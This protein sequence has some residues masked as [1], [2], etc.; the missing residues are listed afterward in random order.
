M[1]FLK[2]RLKAYAGFALRMLVGAVMTGVVSFVSAQELLENIPTGS[3][4]AGVS[5][6][7]SLTL[8]QVLE[9]AF[10][11]NPDMQAAEERI[12][13]AEAK[14]I[15]AT[16]NFYPKLIGQVG[17]TYTDNPAQAFSYI[18][19]QRRFQT[20]NLT[21]INN[22]GYVGNFRPELVG[23]ISLFEGGRD[24][25]RKKAAELGVEVS[26][27][28]RAALHNQLAAAVTA[29]YYAVL[30]APRE[31]EATRRSLAAVDS[32]LAH[33]REMHSA[34]SLL[35]SD[36]LSLEVRQAQAKE[37]ELQTLNAQESART[38][39][40]TLLGLG[41]GDVLDVREQ[42]LGRDKAPSKGLSVNLLSAALAQRPEMQIAA[43]QVEMREKELRA[44]IA[45]HMPRVDAY[46]AY[47]LNEQSPQFNFSKQN[48]TVGINAQIEIFGGGATSARVSAAERK[49]AEA[50]AL[51]ERVRLE[52]DAEVQRAQNNLSEV[53]ARQQVTETAQRSAEEALRLVHEQYRAGASSVT[54]YLEAE[55][56]R[57]ASEMRAVTA[58]FEVQIARAN[59]QKAIGYWLQ[60][61]SDAEHQAKVAAK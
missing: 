27:L 26:E 38:G 31:V 9:L 25:Y 28:E 36:V 1:L 2:N 48:L 57:T 37:R 17:Y 33:A 24:Y 22:P 56:D 16:A 42:Q 30:T 44:E 5:K 51:R 29:A 18:V 12:G 52:I 54:R 43:R 6:N 4:T 60:S 61:D 34:G 55:A 53:E 11:Q 19:A 8:E 59:L 39:L 32:E 45:G 50:Q 14:V 23:T 3:K 10:S 41:T 13:Q 15:E 58:R 20:S 7:Q 35:R 49:V 46:A 47:G 40:K 21:T